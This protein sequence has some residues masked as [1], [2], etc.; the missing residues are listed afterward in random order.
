MKIMCLRLTRF[1]PMLGVL[2][3]AGCGF[4]L[5]QSAPL[6]DGMQRVHLSV[7]G[8]GSLADQ[9]QR[10]LAQAGAEVVGES[11]EGVAELKV[12][13]RFET[14]ALTVSSYA[15]VSEFSVGFHSDFVAETADGKRLFAPQ[16]I[17]MQ[18]EFTYDRTQALGTA[19]R[20]EQIRASLV[21][22]MARAIVRRLQTDS[23][24]PVQHVPSSAT[25]LD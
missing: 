15:K 16:T 25:S 22:D 3:L 12:R 1:L 6:P 5:R 9:L 7:S 17:D 19:T 23:T 14:R 21:T 13:A 10:E 24:E 20:E 4:Q 2:L 8:S 11:G 18:R